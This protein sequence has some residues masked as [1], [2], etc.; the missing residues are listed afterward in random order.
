MKIK[1]LLKNLV[2]IT[3][4]F[5]QFTFAAVWE[6]NRNWDENDIQDFKGW[7]ANEVNRE[8]FSS[9]RSP[10]YGV[11]TDCAD[12]IYGLM[13]IYSYENGLY[14]QIK[15]DE[16]RF[17]DNRLNF[18]DEYEGFERVKEFIH[19]IGK[20]TGTYSLARHNSYPIKV[21]SIG[22]G[23]IYITQWKKGDQL[24]HHAYLIK[25][26]SN[27]GYFRLYSSSTPVRVRV[28]NL[29]RGMPVH[30]FESGP[31]GFKRVAPYY[32]ISKEREDYSHEQ[33]SLRDTWGEDF[34]QNLKKHLAK[35][36]D[37]LSDLL[38]RRFSNFCNLI[39]SRVQEVHSALDYQDQI[40]GRCFNPREYYLYSTPSRD[41][42]IKSNLYSL[43]ADWNKVRTKY[44]RS[45]D[46]DLARTLDF[47]LGRDNSR[48][49]LR[50]SLNLC[51]L[52]VDNDEYTL[53][54]FL[55]KLKEGQISSHPNDSELSRWGADDNRTNCP[56][57]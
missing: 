22:P 19:Y 14:F 12:A 25:A 10:Y 56:I 6:D 1:T 18:L 32:L 41:A 16:K 8:I 27:R 52:K 45:V 11:M 43:L 39:Q 55:V 28:L 57:Y 15:I 9:K 29:R 24:N 26:L 3:V 2:F 21:N 54:Y 53:R 30:L 7:V 40:G 5:S 33:Y 46:K 20:M 37:S 51:P 49:A 44:Y 31:W 23:D 50:A 13:A 35:E 34:F 36:K 47:I 38:E 17:I 48:R 4:F 42:S